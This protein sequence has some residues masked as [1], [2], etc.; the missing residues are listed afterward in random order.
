MTRL[1]DWW[2]V[3]RVLRRE[4]RRGDYCGWRPWWRRDRPFGEKPR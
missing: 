4:E 3:W 2:R 1:L